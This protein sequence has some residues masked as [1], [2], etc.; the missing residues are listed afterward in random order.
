MYLVSLFYKDEKSIKVRI[1]EEEIEKFF[2]DLNASQVYINPDSDVGFWTNV[3]DIRYITTHKEGEQ[4]VK[5]VKGAEPGA[6]DAM[7]DETREDK[8][9]K[10]SRKKSEKA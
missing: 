9:P 10:V 4:D 1:R 7:D 8:R 5:V 3:G 2:A 6:E